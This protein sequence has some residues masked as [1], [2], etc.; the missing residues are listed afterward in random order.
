[1]P[2]AA[3][4][5]AIIAVKDDWASVLAG[6]KSFTADTFLAARKAE[7]EESA[8]TARAVEWAALPPEAIEKAIA[9]IIR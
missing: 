6:G 9:A 8:A 5:E 4:P 1:M 3:P 2:S 7:A